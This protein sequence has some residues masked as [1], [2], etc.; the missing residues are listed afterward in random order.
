MRKL[1]II[2]LFWLSPALG[3]DGDDAGLK[4]TGLAAVDASAIGTLRPFNGGFSADFWQ[5]MTAEQAITAIQDLPTRYSK[6]ELFLLA[7]AILLTASPLN[8]A[9]V[10]A[11]T[12]QLQASS[13]SRAFILA[14]LQ[15][16]YDMGLYADAWE[17]LDLVPGEYYNDSF[18]RLSIDLQLQ[19]G[20][21][22]NAC[23]ALPNANELPQSEDNFWQ[24]L[25]FLC[26]ILDNRLDDAEFILNVLNEVNAFSDNFVLLAQQALGLLPVDDLS[27]GDGG[28][29]SQTLQE[30]AVPLIFDADEN[31]SIPQLYRL[32]QSPEVT[33]EN[34]AL[35]GLRLYRQGIISDTAL[36]DIYAKLPYK[37][38][39]ATA[40]RLLED[41]Y[42]HAYKALSGDTENATS[43][44]KI[45]RSLVL[46]ADGSGTLPQTLR[47]L[48]PYLNLEPSNSLRPYAKIL[49]VAELF[50]GNLQAASAWDAISKGNNPEKPDIYDLL[51]VL[52]EANCQ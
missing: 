12:S 37:K 23:D 48:V 24:K 5:S 43:K 35:I 20:D 30:I 15:K 25:L 22:I 44:A 27:P 2:L 10:E 17:L 45:I 50:K 41:D 11:D 6:A 4:V 28:I 34:K 14:R 46:A 13:V 36:T 40:T 33:N 9:E 18:E 31:Y 32:L 42:P 19:L 38:T 21:N 29:I 7:R 47:Q 3:Q 52:S 51:L 1:F 39:R 26:E 49:A 8:Q 16:L